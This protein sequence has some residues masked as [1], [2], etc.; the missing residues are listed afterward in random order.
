MREPDVRADVAAALRACRFWRGASDESLLALAATARILQVA[1][2]T[3]LAREGDAAE[4]FGVVIQGTVRSVHFGAD[5]RPMTFEITGAGD[6]VGV[7]AALAGGRHPATIEAT[8]PALIAWMTRA[9]LLAFAG[10]DHAAARTMLVSLAG[11]LV[12]LTTV[13]QT[14]SLDVPSR[15]AH[16]IFERSLAGG[17]ATDE[18]LEV[19]LGMRKADLAASLGT[20]PETVS[21]AL[22]KLKSDGVLDVRGR[23]VVIFDVGA[24]ARLGSGYAEG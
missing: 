8:T 17:R 9:S 15:V 10:A 20:V 4:E 11:K 1:R 21:R 19:D 24:L 18:G 23:T 14:L 12:D 22:A 6:A 7:T 5:G 3:V 16:Y 13:V 2:G